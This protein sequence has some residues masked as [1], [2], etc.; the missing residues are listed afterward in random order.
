MLRRARAGAEIGY[1]ADSGIAESK[2]G[3]E[4]TKTEI[5]GGGKNQGR[6]MKTKRGR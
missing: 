6:F 2:Q 4:M 1:D 3:A 5:T